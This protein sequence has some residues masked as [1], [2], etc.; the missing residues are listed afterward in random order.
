MRAKPR[1]GIALL[2]AAILILQSLTAA[3]HGPVCRHHQVAAAEAGIRGGGH[4]GHHAAGHATDAEGG[5]DPSKAPPCTC[6]G[7]CHAGS[8]PLAVSAS[9][10]IAVALPVP[11]GASATFRDDP[12]PPTADFLLPYANAPPVLPLG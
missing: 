4:A 9:P 2:S 6:V 11:A 10:A 5:G 1:R 3:T 7:T 8:L 12:L